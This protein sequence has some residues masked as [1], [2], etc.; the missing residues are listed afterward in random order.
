MKFLDYDQ[1]T[2]FIC[3]SCAKGTI[4][5][6]CKEVATSPQVRPAPK[7]VEASVSEQTPGAEPTTDVAISDPVSAPALVLTTD[8]QVTKEAS[9]PTADQIPTHVSTDEP[10]IAVLEDVEKPREPLLFRCYDCKRVA[11]YR[12]LTAPPRQFHLTSTQEI[13]MAY[14]ELWKCLECE[15]Y[16]RHPLDVVLAW[17]PLPANAPQ[18]PDDEVRFNQ[19][20]EREYLVK[21]QQRGFNRVQWVPHLWLLSTNSQKLKNF[22]V[23]GS[24]V[25]L[26][27]H[28][29]PLERLNADGSSRETSVG[30]LGDD[31]D[32]SNA[33]E[34]IAEAVWQAS[35]HAD[36]LAERRIP[37]AWKTTDRILSVHFWRG[38][39]G[40]KPAVKKT[41]VRRGVIE[42][43]DEDSSRASSANHMDVDDDERA[44]QHMIADFEEGFEIDRNILETID[45]RER[46]LRRKVT[47]EDIDDIVEAYIKWDELR[48]DES[49]W[50]TV[51]SIGSRGRSAF[52][53]AFSRYLVDRQVSIT[54][55]TEAVL[56][57]RERAIRKENF[58]VTET[59]E[60]GQKA[61]YKLM[62]FQV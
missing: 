3:N 7:L 5:M 9:A 28:P 37:L 20:L 42:S 30:G 1:S 54:Y 40:K 55:P 15:A 52:E 60:L 35:F 34:E 10:P 31:G 57:K 13:A 45:E 8:H 14:Q 29:L 38:K 62:P 48:Y 36:P 19:P 32:G 43:E 18:P 49:T 11:H 44:K 53:A 56:E 47:E 2:E 22:M 61:H 27:E 17:R 50:D 39:K 26:L 16:G 51:P 59:P 25:P 21:W 6:C 58:E 4:C 33:V 46:R 24:R 12:C 41:Q 23:K